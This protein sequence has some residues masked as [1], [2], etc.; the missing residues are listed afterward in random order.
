MT[1]LLVTNDFPPTVGGIQSYLRDYVQEVVHR[2]G[3][4]SIIVFAS[5]QDKA[6]AL[7]WDAEQP[8][9]IIRWPFPVMLPTPAVRRMMQRIIREQHVDTVWFGAAA[10][11]GVMGGAAKRAG[12]SRVVATTH[13]HEVGWSMFR[14][15]RRLLRTIGGSADVITYIS[16]YT[17]GRFK[18][19]F[20]PNPQ[21]VALPSGVSTSRYAPATQQ[22]K[23]ET[24][25]SFRIGAESPLIVCASR[26]VKRKGQDRLIRVLP[27]VRQRVPG[28][29]LV[30]VGEGP[31]A[32]RLHAMAEGV[33][34]VRFTGRVSDDD[35]CR[36]V[37]AA[38]V[39]AMPVRTRG[40]GLDVE[41]L[42]IVFLEAQACEVP[43]VAGD[44]G[45]AP[46]TVTDHSGVVVDK[47]DDALVAALVRLLRD[48]LLRES[49]GEAGRRHVQLEF[50]WQVLGERCEKLLFSQ[51]L[52]D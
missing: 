10:P 33:D 5:M 29:Q 14:V 50:S 51:A 24:R 45:G 3:A 9:T 32:R 6:A 43:V 26:L 20:G 46:E 8:Y 34:G 31:Y 12:A 25:A 15:G 16:E 17:L 38:D 27:R 21:F 2:R 18:E 28:A 48:P 30:I 35:L 23:L 1:V 44:S 40:G 39:F 13:G 49:M 36:I 11:L 7:A 41:G 52:G 19:A 42:G 22:E 47:N 4:Q 37:A